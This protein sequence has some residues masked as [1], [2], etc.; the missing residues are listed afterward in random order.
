LIDLG[1]FRLEEPI[2]SGGMAT[3]WRGAHR[4]DGVAVAVKV[5]RASDRWKT[6]GKEQFRTEVRAAAS[7][8]H[9]AVV[10]VLDHGEVSPAAAAASAGRL[11][12]GD[13]YLVME[14]CNGGTLSDHRGALPWPR[15]R[16]VLMTLL[17]ALA[18]AHARG[19]IHRDLKPANVLLAGPGA[20]RPGIK[21]SDFGIAR[22]LDPTAES[23]GAEAPFAGSPAYCPPEQLVG[24]ARD[25]GPHSDL[26]ALGCL[27]WALLCGDPPHARLGLAHLAASRLAGSFPDFEPMDPVP[28]PVVDWLMLLLSTRPRDR[29]A[30]AADAAW[31]LRQAA[32]EEQDVLLPGDALPAVGGQEQHTATRLLSQRA[33]DGLTLVE[34]PE[35]QATR[36]ELTALARTSS[37]TLQERE[38]VPGASAAPTVSALPPIPDDWRRPDRSPEPMKLVGAG[39]GLYAFR[40][41]PLV[42]REEARDR[43]WGALHDVVRDG[44]ARCVVVRGPAGVGKSRLAGWMA[45][46]AEELGAATILRVVHGSLAGSADGLRAA[47]RRHL[48]AEGC[49]GGGLV[50]R[51]RDWLEARGVRDR[52]LESAIVELIAP[53]TAGD[54][55]RSMRLDLTSPHHRWQAWAAAIGTEAARRPVL[56][57][58]DDVQWGADALGL[59]LR[60]VEKR[61]LDRRP[62]LVVATLRD[63]GLAPG[64]TEERRLERLL[65]V[66]GCLELPLRPLGRRHH[67]QLVA[68]LLR[69]DADLA[70]EVVERTG[71]NPLFA[72]Q[73]VGDW[74]RRGV[75]VVGER[76]FERAEGADASI[77]DDIHLLWTA[78]F[79]AALEE[80]AEPFRHA[81][82]VAAA[83]GS[84]FEPEAWYAAAGIDPFEGA[85][86]SGALLEK[87]LWSTA[88]S[89]L[90]FAHGMARESVERRAREADRWRAAHASCAASLAAAADTDSIERR[91][92]H[93]LAAGHPFEAVVDLGA[94]VAARR[95]AG[96]TTA[97]LR[98][99]RLLLQAMDEARIPELSEQRLGAR[100]DLHE[101][102]RLTGAEADERGPLEV[103][104]ASRRAGLA[105]LEAM[106][107]CELGLRQRDAG[108]LTEGTDQLGE[109]LNLAEMIADDR[110]TARA[111]QS[112]AWALVMGGDRDT[113][114]RLFRRAAEVHGRLGDLGG[115]AVCYMGLCE[116]Y[117]QARDFARAEQFGRRALEVAETGGDQSRIGDACVHLA[118][119]EIARRRPEDAARLLERSRECFER[120]GSHTRISA[121]LNLSGEVAR[122]RGDFEA[123]EEAYRESLA[124]QEVT[125]PGWTWLPRLNLAVLAMEAGRFARARTPL[126]KARAQ[127]AAAGRVEQVEWVDILLLPVLL[128]VDDG[129]AFEACLARVEG[130]APSWKRLERDC[131]RALGW[132]PPIARRKGDDR[133]AGRLAA[134]AGTYRDLLED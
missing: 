105:H 55:D 70:D 79:D 127:L 62:I 41:V 27:A 77:P 113:A 38:S 99:T 112:L 59:A 130:V 82:D 13:P 18:H 132:A 119:V 52:Y 48:R 26:Y 45:E 96:E 107:L 54:G 124:I 133:T 3:V 40:A 63:E 12:P 49:A 64:S 4:R 1:A 57:W 106:A 60:L 110:S 33:I 125:A 109:A 30:T 43:I 88:G 7:L 89:A 51:V 16:P 67:R 47:L 25:I 111:S 93:Q 100:L 35:A 104:E 74:I 118:R 19:V 46:R 36:L 15:L 81:I 80:I 101:L 56:L 102:A 78:R 24:P 115:M 97:A 44:L 108:R 126:D 76:G 10:L 69:L 94:A 120:V 90:G 91:G 87:G 66:E 29:F 23:G 5:L 116:A 84:E 14:L 37:W 21:L 17:D 61:A 53:G 32:P 121:T 68:E 83:L 6:D 71:G 31:A 42:G 39:L 65:A 128:T 95:N 8:H 123:A 134:L 122:H 58:L 50:A 9:P 20:L 103:L 28:G 129:E 131:L 72:L 22:V 85:I 73:L 34:T 11:R 114:R 75:L 86:V 92:R 117:T 2:G 98:D